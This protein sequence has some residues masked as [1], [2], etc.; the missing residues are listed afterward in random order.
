[1]GEMIRVQPERTAS[2]DYAKDEV[3]R[4]AVRA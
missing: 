2:Y 3:F 4:A 1:M